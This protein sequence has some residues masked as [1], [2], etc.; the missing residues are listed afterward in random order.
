MSDQKI[1]ARCGSK[2]G[3][4]APLCWICDTPVST[5]SDNSLGDEGVGEATQKQLERLNRLNPKGGHGASLATNVILF[6]LLFA[7]LFGVAG[8]NIY[9]SVVL[10]I[11]GVTALVSGGGSHGAN[12]SKQDSSRGE[13]PKKQQS[14]LG[15]V[16][17]IFFIITGILLAL[18]FVIF[19]TCISTSRW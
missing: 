18:V 16:L 19:L 5:A 4:G 2:I 3:V 7:L 17:S 10:A 15:K 1:C 8:I 6:I 14:L 12:L 13:S 9:I 11:S